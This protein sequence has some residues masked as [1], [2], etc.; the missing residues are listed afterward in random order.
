MSGANARHLDFQV[1]HSL[2]SFVGLALGAHDIERIRA[3][4]VGTH[5]LAERW[6]KQTTVVK[7]R[8]SNE[9]V[10]QVTRLQPN[11]KGLCGEASVAHGKDAFASCGRRVEF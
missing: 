11:L 5:V 9:N 4:R 10:L 3:A 6:V 1:T 8:S 2:H 7:E